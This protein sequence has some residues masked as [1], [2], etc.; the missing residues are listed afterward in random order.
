MIRVFLSILFLPSVLLAQSEMAR[1]SDRLFD[2][3]SLDARLRGRAIVFF[4][5]GQSRFFEDG[6]YTY[7]YADNG[8]TGYGYFKVMEDSTVC[9]A[10]VTGAERCDL[11]VTDSRGRLVVI[12][13]TG[14]RFP[15]RD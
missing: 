8:G 14:D 5:D 6:R 15:T 3:D 10:F 12:T 11:Y 7:T 4:D 2:H 1:E 13:S 9:I